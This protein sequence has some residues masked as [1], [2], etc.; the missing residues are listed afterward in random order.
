MELVRFNDNT[1]G[2]R[3]R[4][5][6]PLEYSF[7]DVKD[8]SYWWYGNDYINKYCKTSYEKA[9][10]IFKRRIDKTKPDVGTVVLK[11]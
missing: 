2:I 10:E 3:R 6:L 11:G 9:F 1:Y 8:E 4:H 7:L 5:W